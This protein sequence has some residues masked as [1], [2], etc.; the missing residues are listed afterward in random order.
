MIIG[1]QMR[2]M[3]QM[4]LNTKLLLGLTVPLVLIVAIAA[5]VY[6][7]VGSLIE[8]SKRVTHTHQSIEFGTAL[9]LDLLNPLK[10]FDLHRAV[11]DM[12]LRR[13]N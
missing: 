13:K 4:K 8:T 2:Q 3:K 12:L 5:V 1:K 9:A 11:V 10:P 7:H 6:T